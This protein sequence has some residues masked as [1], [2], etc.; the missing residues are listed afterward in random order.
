MAAGCLREDIR[1]GPRFCWVIDMEDLVVF[2]NLCVES[3][4]KTKHNVEGFA[5]RPKYRAKMSLNSKVK[6]LM[7]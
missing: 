3:H 5:D 6:F 7:E 4:V 2:E 1:I